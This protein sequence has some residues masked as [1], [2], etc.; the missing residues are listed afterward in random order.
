[1]NQAD[2]LE[3]IMNIST[4]S[5]PKTR[6][7][8]LEPPRV[9]SV[10]SGKGGVGKSNLTT[11]LGYKLATQGKKVLIL[12][13][14]INL[15]NVDILLGLT[16]Q[17]NLHHV[18]M[19]ER[20]LDEVIIEG[21]GGIQILPG[22]SGIMEL[23][24]LSESQKMYFLAEMEEVGKRIDILLID[25]AA[26]INEN[27]VYFNLVAQE[28]IVILTPEPTAL[29]DAYALIKVLSSKHDVKKFRIVINQAATEKEALAVFRQLTLVCDQ[30][31]GTL[32]LDFL[33]YI[34]YDKNLIKA[35]RSQRLVT[36]LF[37]DTPASKMIGKIANQLLEDRPELATDGNIKFFWQRIFEQ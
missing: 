7:Q 18:L 4:T 34:P 23:A 16:P 11:N 25:T 24:T 28:R 1:M 35:V 3:K 22:S 14:D 12:D 8:V 6:G 30:F 27:V 13:A 2:T 5:T 9:L 37:K 15:A 33:G 26:G 29:T 10:T 32:S 17:Y 19:G 21:P 36:E 20:S 31:L